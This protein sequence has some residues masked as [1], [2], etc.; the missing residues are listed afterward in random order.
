MVR[1]GVVKLWYEQNKN[2]KK[3]NSSKKGSEIESTFSGNDLELLDG[4]SPTLNK[5]P[6]SIKSDGSHDCRGQVTDVDFP[7]NVEVMRV[8]REVS[9][10]RRRMEK[11]EVDVEEAE[12]RLRKLM[13]RLTSL[14]G[15]DIGQVRRCK[16][17]IE[18]LFNE[19]TNLKEKRM[20]ATKEL[21]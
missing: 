18:E 6:T 1:Y 14:S 21:L 16:E 2:S 19:T 5:A 8:R 9:M 4:L 7:E 20:A 13:D 10:A 11:A 15:A 3:S 12:Q 17:E